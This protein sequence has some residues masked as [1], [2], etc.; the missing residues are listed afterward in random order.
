MIMNQQLDGEN[1]YITL[2]LNAFLEYLFELTV[3]TVSIL[4]VMLF[5][6][7]CVPIFSNVTGFT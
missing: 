1:E 5:Q 2:K 7:Y 4:V 3:K 6:T